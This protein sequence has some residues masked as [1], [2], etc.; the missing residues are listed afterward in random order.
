MAKMFKTEKTILVV[1]DDPMIGDIISKIFKKKFNFSC[2]VCYNGLEAVKYI[3]SHLPDLILLDVNMPIMNGY[4]ACEKI[5]QNTRT[6]LVPIIFITAFD[7]MDDKVKGFNAGVDDYLVKPFDMRELEVR[8]VSLLARVE[9]FIEVSSKDELTGL[10]NRRYFQDI[11]YHE[12][13]IHMRQNVE[14]SLSMID[15]DF[16]KKVN[17][18]YGHLVGDFILKSFSEKMANFFRKSDILG[19]F[20]GEEFILAFPHTN[21]QLAKWKIEALREEISKEIFV[22]DEKT[23]I[24]F[25]FSAGVSELKKNGETLESLTEAADKSLYL[26]KNQGRNRVIIAEENKNE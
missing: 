18:T 14:L 23:K 22:Y 11:L 13:K 12:I 9:K 24:N 16:F 26:A 3:E 17:D 20:G 7:K 6:N 25:T 4:E 8:V 5:R 19:R 15:I 21:S 2:H 10:Y 1:D